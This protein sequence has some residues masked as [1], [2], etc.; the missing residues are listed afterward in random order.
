MD[1]L[2]AST[3]PERVTQ[4]AREPGIGGI[5]VRYMMRDLVET[6]VESLDSDQTHVALPLAIDAGTSGRGHRIPQWR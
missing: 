3:P 4:I 2:L 6:P 1:A 5:T